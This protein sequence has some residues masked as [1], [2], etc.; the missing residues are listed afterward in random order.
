MRVLSISLIL[1]LAYGLPL[2][3]QNGKPAVESKIEISALPANTVEV[4]GVLPGPG[5][6]Q[7]SKGGHSL[8]ILGS[9]KPTTKNLQWETIKLERKLAE[10]QVLIAPA[11]VSVSAEGGFFSKLGLLP[12]LLKA[13]KNPDGQTLQQVLPAEVYARWVVMK[14]KYIG[15]DKDVENWRPI[16]VAQELYQKALDQSRLKNENIV[17]PVAEDLADEADLPILRPEISIKIAEPKK[18]IKEFSRHA[19]NDTACFEKTLDSIERD[20][21]Y[22]AQR[23]ALWAEG[24]VARLRQIPFNDQSGAC[25]DALLGSGAVQGSGLNDIQ[26]RA[27]TAWLQVAEQALLKNASSVAV[28]NMAELI[29]PNGYL[30]Q[31]Q[32][33]GYSVQE[34]VDNP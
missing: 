27:M 6:W 8:W 18:F 21:Q 25:L 34:P 20:V 11:S 24:N 26:N 15:K 13:K 16:F 3:A 2:Q 10:S 14:A 33:R 7:V 29:K 32:A 1:M 31:L 12:S 5:F 19:L 30:A 22:M 9:V 23:G 17:W 28:V 4:K